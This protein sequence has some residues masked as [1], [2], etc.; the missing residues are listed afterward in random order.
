[1]HRLSSFNDGAVHEL[2][3]HLCMPSGLKEESGWLL[4]L[5]LFVFVFDAVTCGV[6]EKSVARL[7]KTL[8][9]HC[10]NTLLSSQ[11]PG[12]KPSAPLS[13]S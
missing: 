1:M 3:A 2:V 10:A 12:T 9:G 8:L 7:K 11:D 6:E 5:L 4:L 13:I